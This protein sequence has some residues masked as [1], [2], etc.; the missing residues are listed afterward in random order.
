MKQN[1]SP[2]NKWL[3]STGTQKIDLAEMLE[4]SVPNTINLCNGRCPRPKYS[5][6]L[7]LHKI[8]KIP[9]YDLAAFF[10]SRE[11]QKLLTDLK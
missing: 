5:T 1:R 2:I 9:V 7:K 6:L 8:T 10:A 11:N 4:L 3:K